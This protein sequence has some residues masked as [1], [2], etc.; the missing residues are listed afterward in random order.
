MSFDQPDAHD[1]R[2]ESAY[3]RLGLLR[4]LRGTVASLAMRVCYSKSVARP[5]GC[6]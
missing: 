2:M 5:V 3:E 1:A 6:S 4:M